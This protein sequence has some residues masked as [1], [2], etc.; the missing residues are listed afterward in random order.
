VYALRIA[1]TSIGKG[2]ESE[3]DRHFGRAAY[4]VIVDTETMNCSVFEN[5]SADAESGAGISSDRAIAG[6]GVQAMLTGNCGPDAERMLRAAGVRLYTGLVGT[7]R[8]AVELF[9]K[10]TL[11]EAEGPSVQAHFGADRMKDES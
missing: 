11:K 4:F 1:V 10:G 5:D 9:R 6:A 7:V 3:I 8:E 2:L